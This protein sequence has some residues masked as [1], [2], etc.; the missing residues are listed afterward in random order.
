MLY[1]MT[2]RSQGINENFFF[3][4]EEEIQFVFRP[5]SPSNC[6]LCMF[7]WLLLHTK[8][9][10]TSE[11]NAMDNMFRRSKPR[12]VKSLVYTRDQC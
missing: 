4:M 8:H 5:T 12:G 2:L 11:R 7:I 1:A 3:M 9:E 6:E 10:R